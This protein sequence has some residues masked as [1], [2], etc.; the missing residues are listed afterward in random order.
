M[1]IRAATFVSRAAPETDF[2]FSG[3][4]ADE[5]LRSVVCF[6]TGDGEFTALFAGYVASPLVAHE[7]REW[8]SCRA[9]VVVSY[10]QSYICRAAERAVVAQALDVQ[11]TTSLAIVP[12]G[13]ALLLA[14]FTHL[15]RFAPNGTRDWI[16]DRVSYDG[17]RALAIDG[18]RCTLEGWDAPGRR[19]VPVEVDLATGRAEGSPHYTAR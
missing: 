8:R 10:G 9:T 4:N 16:S 2:V 5:R 13:S 6:E 7:V 11:P 19:F 17:I 3:P 12:D 15:H 18:D 1:S 14:D